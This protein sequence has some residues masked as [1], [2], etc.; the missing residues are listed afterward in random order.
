LFASCQTVANFETRQPPHLLFA[1]RKLALFYVIAFA[2]ISL[3]IFAYRSI[4]P[5]AYTMLQ[6]VTIVSALPIS[7]IIAPS[8]APQQNDVAVGSH[9]DGTFGYISSN[10]TL[11]FHPK[12]HQIWN[13]RAHS[14]AQISPIDQ[15]E[16][17]L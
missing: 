9:T 10:P 14:S 16:S 17:H 11:M 5:H 7:G 4:L 3:N 12:I 1:I 13:Y 2:Y 15:Q 6:L 8:P